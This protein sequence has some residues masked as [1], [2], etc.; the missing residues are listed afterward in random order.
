MASITRI[1]CPVDFSEFSRNALDHA[2]AI[3]RWYAA[4]VTALHVLPS[5]TVVHQRRCARDTTVRMMASSPPPRP[6]P[7]TKDR[8]ILSAVTGNR[9]RYAKEE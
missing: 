2:A 6:M 5:P 9:F 4:D 7:S 3:A 1:L 8:S